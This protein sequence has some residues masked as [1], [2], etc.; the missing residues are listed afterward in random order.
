[1]DVKFK[2]TFRLELLSM[3]SWKNK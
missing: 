3:D 1:M 2:M